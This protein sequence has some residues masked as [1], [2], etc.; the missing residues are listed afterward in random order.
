MSSD[1]PSTSTNDS[2]PID[3]PKESHDEIVEAHRAEHEQS[4]K[5]Y[6]SIDHELDEAESAIQQARRRLAEHK[7]RYEERAR[8]P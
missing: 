2:S 7:R 1:N 4:Q 6:E 8:V 3:T 5:F